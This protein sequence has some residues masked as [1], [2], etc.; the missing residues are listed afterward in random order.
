[1]AVM[2]TTKSPMVINPIG[3]AIKTFERG[4]SESMTEFAQSLIGPLGKR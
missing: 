1:M 2:S 3:K 4:E